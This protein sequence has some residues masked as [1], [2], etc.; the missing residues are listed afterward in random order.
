MVYYLTIK[1]RFSYLFNLIKNIDL[2][3]IYIYQCSFLFRWI[4]VGS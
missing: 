4:Y 2:N 1:S 3:I